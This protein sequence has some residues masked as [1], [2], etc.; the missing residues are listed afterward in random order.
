MCTDEGYHPGI[1]RQDTP[2]GYSTAGYTT[3]VYT[4]V[5]GTNPGIYT[6]ERY[7]PGYG[8][9]VHHPGMG[10]VYTT[11]YGR[12]PTQC[13]YPTIPPWVYHCTHPSC[14]QHVHGGISA[15]GRSPGLN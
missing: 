2:P 4:P 13:I 1:A 7:Q 3:R 9:G 5:R 6:G 12:L 11:G 8:R 15:E 14:T 10:E